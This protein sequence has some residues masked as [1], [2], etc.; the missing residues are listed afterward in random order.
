IRRCEPF[1]L[2]SSGAKLELSVEYSRPEPGL[3]TELFVKF[4]RDFDDAFRDRRRGELESEINLAA[5]SRLPTFPTTVPA[6]V[7]GDIHRES[8]T[9]LLITER[10]PL[11]VA[12][13]EPLHHKCMD[14][15]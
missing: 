6:A 3:P 8:G 12:P 5:L 9:G 2:G 13:I 7:F 10:I 1:L 15:E 14:H 4:S 11:G